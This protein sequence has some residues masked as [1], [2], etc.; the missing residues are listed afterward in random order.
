M[1]QRGKF[2]K[3]AVF[4]GKRHDNKNLKAN[5]LSRKF[6]VIAQAPIAVGLGVV[7]YLPSGVFGVSN[8][9]GTIDFSG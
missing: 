8:S 9:C 1:G 7:L 5:F 6:V 2:S 4:R 3:N